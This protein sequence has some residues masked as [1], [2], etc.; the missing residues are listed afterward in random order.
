MKRFTV[1]CLLSASLLMA[2]C[3]PATVAPPLAP[4]Y[5]N[6]ADQQMG[7]ILSGARAFYTKIQADSASGATTLSPQEKSSFQSFGVAINAAEQVYLAYHNGQAT[8]AAAQAA[9][10]IVSQQQAALPIPGGK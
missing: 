9:V 2:G 5:A 10:N 6:Q 8:Q 4:G 3:T 1:L 7:Q